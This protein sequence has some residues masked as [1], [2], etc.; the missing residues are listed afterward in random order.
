MEGFSG[1]QKGRECFPH[2]SEKAIFK[3][4]TEN[5]TCNCVN[6]VRGFFYGRCPIFAAEAGCP[7]DRK[8]NCFVN[9]GF[10]EDTQPFKIRDP[11]LEE[12]NT[13]FT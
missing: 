4:A 11:T 3:H 5:W 7:V 1:S 13:C 2:K 10:T 9:P 8:S 12:P 6:W